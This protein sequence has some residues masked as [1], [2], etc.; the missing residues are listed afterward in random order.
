M[1]CIAVTANVAR[2]WRT[3]PL[4]ATYMLV[5]IA[6]RLKTGIQ[7]EKG[8]AHAETYQRRLVRS[9]RSASLLKPKVHKHIQANSEYFHKPMHA[10]LCMCVRALGVA[11]FSEIFK[12]ASAQP[13]LRKS[14]IDADERLLPLPL[15]QL[16]L[17]AA[18]V[19]WVLNCL[20]S[21]LISLWAARQLSRKN[22]LCHIFVWRHTHTRS[23]SYRRTHTR[24]Q[25]NKIL[26][27]LVADPVI[28]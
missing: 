20:A 25:N 1:F 28:G 18:T 5:L 15:P 6:R 9:H 19:R 4:N 3:Q 13:V 11:Y 2:W 8:S 10:H 12:R 24:T 17:L 7:M 23:H 26:V 16:L 21:I 27:I 22:I 14:Q